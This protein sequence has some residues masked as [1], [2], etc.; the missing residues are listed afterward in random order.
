MHTDGEID[1][2]GAVAGIRL[3]DSE[4]GRASPVQVFHGHDTSWVVKTLAYFVVEILPR[5][6]I[7]QTQVD[8][9]DPRIPV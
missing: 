7:L 2:T 8:H 9:P 3:P 1:L 6:I 4:P 5:S